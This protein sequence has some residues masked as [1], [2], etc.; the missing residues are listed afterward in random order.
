MS[1]YVYMRILE[2]A[3]R[4]YDLGI[5]LLSLGGVN[6][7]YNAVAAAA[8]GG[9]RA[10]RVLEIGC[11]TGSLTQV[12]VGHGAVVTAID[13]NPEMLA[14]AKDKLAIAKDR[15]EFK[16]MAAVEI[17]DRFPADGFDAI[18]STLVLSEMS[19]DEQRYVLEAAHK[20]L[21]PG[22]RLVMG[23]EVKPR[24]FARRCL[25]A[26][27][28]W[29]LAVVTYVLTQTTT[30]AVDDLAGLIAGAG[31]RVLS[32]TRGTQ[33]SLAVVVAQKDAPAAAR[34]TQGDA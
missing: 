19:P 26:C 16:E 28:R 31:F 23:D 18:A 21:R 24:G 32:E 5:R 29:P 4:R 15:V 27:L 17:A 2:S 10:P 8:V 6:R 14:I 33:G 30:A 25:H 20:V 22:G 3:P 7:L 34:S 1:T 12:L 13:W 9:T 11:G